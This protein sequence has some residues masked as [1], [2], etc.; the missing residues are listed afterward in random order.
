MKKE[1]TRRGFLGAATAAAAVIG[2]PRAAVGAPQKPTSPTRGGAE[3]FRFVH[4]ADMHVQPE[5]RADKGLAKCLQAVE[6]LEPKPDFI[7]TGGDLVMDVLGQ[8]ATRA[9]M[10][11]GLYRKI[12]NDHTSIPVHECIGNHDVFGWMNKKGVTPN[13][14]D[15]GK[16]MVR[17]FLELPRTY[18]RF[19]HK[20]WRFF[21]LDDIQPAP[22][23]RHSYVAYIDQPQL[24]W[25]EKEL[26]A[27]DPKM[28]AAVVC[29]IPILSITVLD[30]GKEAFKDETYQVPTWLMC[31]DA[32]KLAALFSKHN[33]RLALSGHIHQQDRIEYRDV[34][35][36]CTGAVSGNW[37]DGPHKG[38]EEGFGIL[39]V[40]PNGGVANR[41]HDYGWQV[42]PKA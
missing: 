27:K 30:W 31:R 35:Y 37:W 10:L 28:P 21:V 38:C 29:H 6:A 32:F 11:F 4:L 14:P 15:Y 12:F 18:Y 9:K 40:D 25:L 23:A 36:I 17:D 16:K 24:A 3:P 33:V 20:G 1:L 19:D 2:L 5:R 42:E 26:A 39:D 34:T 8:D 22:E 7:L 13:H 41:Y